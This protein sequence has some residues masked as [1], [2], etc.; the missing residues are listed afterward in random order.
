MKENS[1]SQWDI[2][3]ECQESTFLQEENAGGVR[4]T[5]RASKVMQLV[6]STAM[7]TRP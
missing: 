3:K 5:L 6:P 2:F 1:T 4:E 7:Y